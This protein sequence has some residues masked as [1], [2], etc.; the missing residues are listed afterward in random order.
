MKLAI[1]LLF[2]TVC[3]TTVLADIVLDFQIDAEGRVGR[4]GDRDEDDFR[5]GDWN[6]RDDD[7][8]RRRHHHDDDGCCH[9]KDGRPGHDG[10]D[11]RRGRQLTRPFGQVYNL[12]VETIPTAPTVFTGGNLITYSSNGLS[13]D[14][15]HKP[16][17]SAVWAEHAGSYL[18][19]AS[20][21]ADPNA[22]T[23]SCSLVINGVLQTSPQYT[24]IAPVQRALTAIVQ[25]PSKAKLELYCAA[26]NKNYVLTG[27]RAVNA[28]LVLARL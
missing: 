2:V 18:V 23:A 27:G 6:D 1:I 17:Q 3:L 9:G 28:N 26:L 16:G 22:Q 7:D 4:R 13:H 8:F 24:Y 5:R 14:V 20:L 10:Q 11:G 12:A 15:H 21:A 25:L 19:T